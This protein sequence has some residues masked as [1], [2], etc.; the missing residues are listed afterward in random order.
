MK[1]KKLCA[2]LLAALMLMGCIAGCGND[3]KETT[4]DSKET[5]GATDAPTDAPTEAEPPLYN[6]DGSLPLVNEPVTLK[7]LTKDWPNFASKESDKA[8][9]WKW[10]EEKT[11]IHFEV[12]SYPAEE[13]KTK[14]P[15]I[16]ASPD[17]M[18]D[19]FFACDFTAADVLSYG[20]NG[21]LLMLDDYIEKYGKNIKECFDTLPEAY[22]A[23]A[24]ADGHIYSLPSFNGRD[25]VAG[26]TFGVSADWLERVGVEMPSTVEE[27]F[28]VFQAFEAHGDPNG[29]GIKGNEI[30]W[31]GWRSNFTSNCYE[32]FG[33]EC[34]WP[35]KGCTYSAVDD[36]VFFVP[37]SDNYKYM[38]TVVNQF[39]EA[40][41][42]DP[43]V[44]TQASKEFVVKQN[45]DLTFILSAVDN[46]EEAAYAGRVGETWATPLGSAVSDPIVI[47]GASY[48]TDIGLVS[49]N[50]K[51]PEVCVLLLDYLFSEEASKTA[52][53]GQE[54]IDYR[55][56]DEENFVLEST[57]KDWLVTSGLTPLLV[58]R[59][60][61]DEWAQPAAN[62]LRQLK[63][64]IRDEY[65]V[66]CWQNYVKFTAEEAET[67]N[68][69]SADLGGFC[70]DYFVGFITGKYDI[71]KDW[72]AYVKECESMKLAELTAAYQT[73][74]NRYF[75]IK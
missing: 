20:Q 42:I 30:Y 28:E 51:Y 69:I 16:M 8:L 18:P 68:F 47:T 63:Q 70:D 13:L 1:F 29:D 53:F 12:T 39:Y 71:E 10:L 54:G 26:E 44:F 36:K 49:A 50:T 21:Q 56:V 38:L 33:L 5:T 57:S 34:Y 32:M 62:E 46:P 41:Y 61:R 60:A 72:D 45:A 65:G 66:F 67:V 23:A 3:N 52:Y 4:A 35:W 22:G 6:E 43:D 17:E 19:I 73:A 55:V 37:T 74:Y 75:G 64:D 9:L 58:S 11:G 24:A 48:Q 7:V 2:L 40:G 27:L 59:W 25:G 15:L 14:L 31:S